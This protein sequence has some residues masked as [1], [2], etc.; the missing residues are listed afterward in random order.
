MPTFSEVAAGVDALALHLVGDGQHVGG[1]DGDDVGLEVDDEPD[2]AFGHAAGDGYDGAAEVFGAGVYAEAAG[3][4]AV[5]VGVVQQLAGAGA[6]G[7]Q[8]SGHDG[9][10]VCRSSVV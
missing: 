5:A 4:Q 10:Q 7:A 8:A 1:G 3:E 6:G 2:L 9:A